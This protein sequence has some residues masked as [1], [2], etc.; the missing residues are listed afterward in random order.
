MI[1][2]K[3]NNTF[4]LLI[5]W[6]FQIEFYNLTN[7]KNTLI[8]MAILLSISLTSCKEKSNSDSLK[9]PTEVKMNTLT[10]E[11]QSAG[12]ELLFNGKDLSGWKKYNEEEV[13]GW[14]V[15]DGV[16]H[17]SGVGSDHG[18]DIITVTQDYK[19][20]EL[21]LEWNINT[22]SNSGVF[23]HAQD[24]LEDGI[25][26]TGIEYQLIDGAGWTSEIEEYQ[27]SGALYAMYP[28][29]GAELKP[30]GEW[31]SIRIIVKG[32]QIEHWLNGKKVVECELWSDDWNEKRADSKWNDMPNW[33]NAKEG[34]IGLQD[35]GGLT[36]FRN[37]KI[38]KL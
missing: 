19:D 20:F 38:R 37:L 34:G 6:E 30:V 3:I 25:Y 8:L 36:K 28:A 32:I 24:G 35:H 2:L 9:K 21:Y 10:A 18:G 27:K 31:N 33:G 5:I 14:K 22:Q 7:M 29:I 26:A 15:I 13:T 1:I 23:Y 4:E 17:N 11:E 16:M 12:W